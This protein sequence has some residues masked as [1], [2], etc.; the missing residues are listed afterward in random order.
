VS[1]SYDVAPDGQRFLVLEPAES[2]VAS[3]THLNVVL[4]WF[5]E[6]KQKAGT[7]RSGVTVARWSF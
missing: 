6:L 3:V 2:Q 4:N 5:E 1:Q 7:A